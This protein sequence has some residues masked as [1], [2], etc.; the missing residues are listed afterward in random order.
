MTT[1][2]AL[3]PLE[4]GRAVEVIERDENGHLVGSWFGYWNFKRQT[5]ALYPNVK[6]RFVNWPGGRIPQSKRLVSDR[7]VYIAAQKAV[8]PPKAEPPKVKT[9]S[10]GRELEGQLVMDFK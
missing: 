10:S 2:E 6:N 4:P 3:K 7:V 9:E 5:V 8:L 1:Y